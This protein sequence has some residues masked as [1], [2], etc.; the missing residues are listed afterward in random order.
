MKEKMIYSKNINSAYILKS[1]RKSSDFNDN[2]ESE[3]LEDSLCSVEFTNYK[4]IVLLNGEINSEASV[5]ITKILLELQNKNDVDG[6]YKPIHFI[7]NSTGGSVVDAWQ[8]C[9]IMDIIHYPIITIGVGEIASAALLI[10]INGESGFRILSHRTSIMSHQYSW[11]VIGKMDD[12]ISASREFNN[13]YERMENHFREKTKL[14]KK[15]IR[16]KLLSGLDNWM[17][18]YD[19][20]KLNLADMV[21]DFKKKSPFFNVNTKEEWEQLKKKMKKAKE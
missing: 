3:E 12:L 5:Q 18:P 13:I 2:D 20:L 1:K 6:V 14:S 11:G 7:I 8:I 21:L 16:K 10:F 19:A 17:K 4:N 9:D 15:V